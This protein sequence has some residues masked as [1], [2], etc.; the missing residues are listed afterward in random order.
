MGLSDEEEEGDK[1]EGE[2]ED[3]GA[4]EDIC[5]GHSGPQKRRALEGLVE[6]LSP[7]ATESLPNL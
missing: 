2:K 6:G 1:E 7:S 5:I 3:C 4:D